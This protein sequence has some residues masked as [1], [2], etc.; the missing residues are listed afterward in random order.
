MKKI[1]NDQND[2]KDIRCFPNLIQ[3][4][5][6]DDLNPKS[7]PLTKSILKNINSQKKNNIKR[8]IQ[9]II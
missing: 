6:K 9:K 3:Y 4:N 2:V 5:Y 8:T 7:I 1:E